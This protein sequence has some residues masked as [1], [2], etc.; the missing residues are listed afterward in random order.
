MTVTDQKGLAKDRILEWTISAESFLETASVQQNESILWI[1]SASTPSLTRWVSERAQITV[2]SP[3]LFT[4]KKS[5]FDV[6]A[7]Q[8]GIHFLDEGE[9]WLRKS[10]HLLKP[11]GRLI[12]DLA[13]AITLENIEGKNYIKS[14]PDYWDLLREIGFEAIF[15]Q[16][17]TVRS[18]AEAMEQGWIELTERAMFPAVVNRFI[19]LKG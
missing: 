16:Q 12:I 11:G 8:L 9:E 17:I 15:V 13:E 18:L 14:L 7:A 4:S 6:A 1:G 2:I 19:A 10:F 3:S 5:Q